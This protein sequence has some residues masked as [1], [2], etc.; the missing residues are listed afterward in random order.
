MGGGVVAQSNGY[1][2][3]HRLPWS[4][5]CLGFVEHARRF[6]CEFFEHIDILTDSSGLHLPPVHREM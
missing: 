5:P 4:P 3:S 2:P 6:R 1:S